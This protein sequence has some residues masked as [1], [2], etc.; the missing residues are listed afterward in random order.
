MPQ[1]KFV[2]FRPYSG[3][4]ADGT[5]EIA[6]IDEIFNSHDKWYENHD[7]R[8][9]YIYDRNIMSSQQDNAKVTSVRITNF[10]NEFSLVGQWEMSADHFS[11]FGDYRVNKI[12]NQEDTTKEDTRQE[13]TLSNWNAKLFLLDG[14]KNMVF[15]ISGKSKKKENLT[16]V[17]LQVNY[18]SPKERDTIIKILE[19]HMTKVPK[20]SKCYKKKHT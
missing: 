5:Y 11:M 17:T 1:L 7:K 6:E 15:D 8:R 16:K 18:N 14:N 10:R 3:Y 20:K 19:P 9:L 13:L 2:Y 12:H 4:T